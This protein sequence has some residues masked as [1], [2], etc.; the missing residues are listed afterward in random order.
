LIWE[1][2]EKGKKKKVN[3][4]VK[5]EIIEEIFKKKIES[6]HSHFKPLAFSNF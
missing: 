6:I 5:I 1:E 3:R 2:R 4:K